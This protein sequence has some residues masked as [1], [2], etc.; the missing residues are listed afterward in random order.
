ME[1][2]FEDLI[3]SEGGFDSVPEYM[4]AFLAWM[5][6]AGASPDQIEAQRKQFEHDLPLMERDALVSAGVISIH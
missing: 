6:N 1:T 5:K 4:A 3:Y 2:S